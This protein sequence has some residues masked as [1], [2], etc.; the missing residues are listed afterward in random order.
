MTL[1]RGD[2]EQGILMLVVV[3]RCLEQGFLSGL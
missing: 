2:E 3:G 1:G